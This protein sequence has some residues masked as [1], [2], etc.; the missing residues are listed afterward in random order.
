MINWV[1][2]THAKGHVFHQECLAGVCE[3]NAVRW[4]PVSG[5]REAIFW[6]KPSARNLSLFPSFFYFFF[7]FFKTA[8]P[9]AL[10]CINV[11]HAL[12]IPREKHGSS[13][14]GGIFC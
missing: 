4:A 8:R 14:C 10:L 5:V 6:L 2:V 11:A 1:P 9:F 12:K 13:C 3:L 7:F